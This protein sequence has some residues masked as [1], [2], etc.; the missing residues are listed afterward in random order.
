M[1][2]GIISMHYWDLSIFYSRTTG[3]WTRWTLLEIL[4][5]YKENTRLC[6]TLFSYK[7]HICIA[8]E[9]HECVFTFIVMRVQYTS[10]D[11]GYINY[12]CRTI[13]AYDL[14]FIS[15]LVATEYFHSRSIIIELIS[16]YW[17]VWKWN[18]KETSIGL[19]LFIM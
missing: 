2:R 10:V 4:I 13:R 3:V 6:R 12:V 18:K 11:T 15:C 17:C 8:Q 14:S 19:I 16:R 1:Y 9:E 5:L 7:T